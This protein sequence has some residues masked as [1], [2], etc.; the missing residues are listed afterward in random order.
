[1]ASA[2]T[3]A[4]N[5]KEIFDLLIKQEVWTGQL[6]MTY[7][8]LFPEL[9]SFWGQLAN[10]ENAHAALLSQLSGRIDNATW[11]FDPG[12]FNTVGLRTCCE[13]LRKQI[14]I[15]CTEQITLV[16]ALATAMDVETSMIEKEFFRVATTDTSV[17]RMEFQ[18]LS[19]ET[20][21]HGRRIAARLAEERARL[22]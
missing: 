19:A 18:T 9:D 6:Y 12:K 5:Q 3:T 7:Q 8:N 21:E 16:R 2:P 11:F 4:A 15:A 13:H 10:E 17:G 22:A 1:M 14:Q 20:K